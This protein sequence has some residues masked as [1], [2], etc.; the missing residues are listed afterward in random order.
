MLSNS[1][2]DP[3]TG[4]NGLTYHRNR[5]LYEREDKCKVIIIISRKRTAEKVN[6]RR[7]GSKREV[8]VVME[9]GRSAKI[10]FMLFK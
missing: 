7:L 9:N 10:N 2:H 6:Q 1:N 8:S 3:N 5:A 4:E